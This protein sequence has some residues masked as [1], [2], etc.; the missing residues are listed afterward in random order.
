MKRLLLLFLALA[1]VATAAVDSKITA[2]TVYTDRAVVTRTATAE[3]KAGVN[4]L[5]LAQLPQGLD[6]RSLQ[7]T[8]SG[9][10]RATILDVSARQ[11]FVDF[12]AH[13][14]V[15][16]LETQLKTLLREL[17]NVDDRSAVLAAQGTALDRMESA[18]FAAPTKEDSR[19]DVGKFSSYLAYLAEERTK[20]A[21]ARSDLDEQRAEVQ[22][23]IATVQRQLNELRGS[24]QRAFKSVTVRVT[25]ESA[26]QLDLVLSYTVAG[27]SWT[28]TYDAR[29]AGGDTTIALGYFG[30]VRQNT[31]ED[32]KDVALTLSTARPAL[33]GA[34]P[35][36][37]P[38][39]LEV[40]D[41]ARA[42]KEAMAEIELAQF[43]RKM[44]AA[45][46]ATFGSGGANLAMRA[47][48][49]TAEATVDTGTTSATFRIAAP[50]SIASDNSPQK[51]PVTTAKLD[52]ALVYHTTPK[53]APTA[54]LSAAVNNNSEFPLLAGAMNVF[55]D[56]TFVATSRL[57]NVM[58]GEKF[59]LA[60]G[61]D[62]G[63][64]IEHKRV[65]KFTEQTGLLSRSTRVTYE[66]LVTLRNNK[67]T[68]AR[69]VVTDQVPLS[70]N[71]KITVRVQSPPDREV[72][73]DAEGL[74]KWTL[75]LKP[76]EKR[77]LT[78][79]FTIEHANDVTV[80]GLE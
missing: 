25:A 35:K 31:G 49:D 26:G 73:P 6:D 72:K 27:A 65:Q 68:P 42:R 11:A 3:L 33:G 13:P 52:A 57:E 51:V 48:A 5:V 7:V 10:A 40:Y 32:W 47:V 55:L 20:L 60:L 61:A 79:K 59:D 17:R 19:P 14:R 15:Q 66:Y 21:G 70:R 62:E 9:T 53:L 46:S 71:E 67:R 16:E 75:D 28:P 64:A 39:T 24:G 41:E 23:R 29:I 44:V 58:P 77:D 43:Q 63:I 1:A 76:A 78:I 74:L 54:Y 34:A 2:V 22:N 36:L 50:T 18:F 80:T 12:A 56:G 30:L 4:E 45:P 37:W 8:G 38:W 69:V